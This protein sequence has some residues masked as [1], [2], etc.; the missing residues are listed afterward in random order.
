[1]YQKILV[2]MALD[3]EVSQQTLKLARGFCAPDG[4]VIALHVLEEPQGTANAKLREDLIAEGKDR[5]TKLF[6]Q[7]LAD[8]PNVEP[9]IETGHVSRTIIEVAQAEGVDCIVMGSHKP[10]F[11]EYLIGS[12]AARVVRHA[13]CSVH[14][15]RSA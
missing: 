4:K 8:H 15:Y 5:A 14:V 3:H 9:M 12:N 11:A 1:M 2:A 13:P 10:G 6:A 7:K